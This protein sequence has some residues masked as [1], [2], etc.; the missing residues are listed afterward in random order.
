MEIC[1]N[2]FMKK[3][4]FLGIF[5]LAVGMFSFAQ[6]AEQHARIYSYPPNGIETTKE[7]IPLVSRLKKYFYF[8]IKKLG[9]ANFSRKEN[10]KHRRQI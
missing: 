10:P 6:G 7:I 9:Y 4:L 2:L 8:F 5:I 1:Y 3:F